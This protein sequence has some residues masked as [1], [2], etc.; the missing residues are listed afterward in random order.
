MIISNIMIAVAAFGIGLLLSVI[1]LAALA[2]C[3]YAARCEARMF[4]GPAIWGAM[5]L[6]FG[7]LLRL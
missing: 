7:G 3:T 6:P 2:D 1:H 4:S 5:G